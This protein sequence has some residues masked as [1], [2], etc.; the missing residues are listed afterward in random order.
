MCLSSM[1]IKSIGMDFRYDLDV[2]E[3]QKKKLRKE[4]I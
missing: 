3:Q 4:W 1:A 2:S